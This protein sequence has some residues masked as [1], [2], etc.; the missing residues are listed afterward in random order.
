[1]GILQQHR[2]DLSPDFSRRP[3]A[4][5]STTDRIFHRIVPSGHG[6]LSAPWTG[7]FTGFLPQAMGV[8]QHHGPDLSPDLLDLLE[9]PDMLDPL[10]GQNPVD[11]LCAFKVMY[12]LDALDG[13]NLVDMLRA[14]DVTDALDGIARRITRRIARRTA[15]SRRLARR[16]ARE[17][18]RAIACTIAR[19]MAHQIDRGIA[20]EIV[21]SIAGRIA[22]RIARRISVSKSFEQGMNA[23]LR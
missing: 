14:F 3:W 18:V 23:P 12:P 16:I 9:P 6:Y 4:S 13:Q 7:S 20:C 1:V 22:R 2:P 21:R 17:V 19:R 5:Y 8:L 11:T 15:R 10:D